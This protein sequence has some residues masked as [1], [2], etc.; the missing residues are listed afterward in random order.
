MQ[1]RFIESDMPLCLRPEDRF[2]KSVDV[3]DVLFFELATLTSFWAKS[4]KLYQ[5]FSA[6]GENAR[7]GITFSLDKRFYRLEGELK[8]IKKEREQYLTLIEQIAPIEQVS[9]REHF[10]EEIRSK[11]N[12]Y[13]LNAQ[14]LQ[15]GLPFKLPPAPELCCEM[16]DISI[17]GLCLV[18]N[19]F[20]ESAYEPLFLLEFK[21]GSKNSFLLPA[22]LVRKGQCP[23]TTL[24]NYDY[25]FG[26]IFDHD[27][28]E[29]HRLSDA[30][31]SSKLDR[32]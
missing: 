19:E 24:F 23:Q 1:L 3:F 12:V 21:L 27:P 17:G 26:F 31:F 7:V 8:T 4:E 16:F 29:K 32:M 10:R 18:G 2:G 13:G 11:V 15:K 28:K 22:K 25:G 9:Q 14:D 6:L 20:F 5:G 30:I